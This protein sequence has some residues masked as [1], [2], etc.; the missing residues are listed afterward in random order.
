VALSLGI[1]G[2]LIFLT[3]LILILNKYNG[4]LNYLFF[5]GQIIVLS[6]MVWEDTLE[7]QA[8][9]AVFSLLLNLFIFERK[10]LKVI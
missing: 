2:I 3:L 4:S 6:S 8:G 7:T 9:V 10:K 1:F 5:L